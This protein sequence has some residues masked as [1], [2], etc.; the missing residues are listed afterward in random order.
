MACAPPPGQVSS[1]LGLVLVQDDPEQ[2]ASEAGTA[3]GFG[4]APG[5]R[6]AFVPRSRATRQVSSDSSEVRGGSAVMRAALPPASSHGAAHPSYPPVGEHMAHLIFLRWWLI[7]TAAGIAALGV[8]RVVPTHPVSIGGSHDD[9][10][11]V[12]FSLKLAV[13]AAVVASGIAVAAGSEGVLGGG[14]YVEV[15]ALGAPA[16]YGFFTWI[17]RAQWMPELRLG[18]PRGRWLH[19]LIALVL[20]AA[21]AWSALYP[22]LHWDARTGWESANPS[23]ARHLH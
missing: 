1:P 16:G 9:S 21:T 13:L 15:L 10:T 19:G 23:A 8:W 18:V 2:R 11:L 17:H 7:P 14:M 20:V 22:T 5:A 3:G 12:S 6:T 4:F